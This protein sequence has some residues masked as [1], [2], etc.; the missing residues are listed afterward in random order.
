M[1]EEGTMAGSKFKS[2]GEYMSAQPRAVRAVLK[3]VR[4]AIRRAVPGV[5]EAIGYQILAYKLGGKAV[6]H[7]G[8][9]KEHYSLYAATPGVRSAFKDEL[10]PYLVEKATIRFP[11]S[12]PVP[13]KLIEG[14]ARV[15]AKEN[16]ERGRGKG[17]AKG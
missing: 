3:Q 8:A 10:A 16:A 6:L 17:R 11:L 15:R 12:E 1:R 4:S 13:V 14:I 5:E 7:V 2:A 9:W